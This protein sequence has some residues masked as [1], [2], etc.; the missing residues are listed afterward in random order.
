VLGASGEQLVDQLIHRD[1]PVGSPA[2]QEARVGGQCV[3]DAAPF[4]LVGGNPIQH[5][6]D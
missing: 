5:V 3:D 2:G 1:R 4:G 6:Q